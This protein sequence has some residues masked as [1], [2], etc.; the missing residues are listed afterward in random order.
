MK[1][2]DRKYIRYSNE[3][4]FDVRKASHIY[5]HKSHKLDHKILHGDMMIS[6]VTAHVHADISSKSHASRK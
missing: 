6:R 2:S 5:I 4:E 3:F 1:S